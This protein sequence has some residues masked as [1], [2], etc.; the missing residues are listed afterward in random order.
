MIIDFL[1]VNKIA[2][3]EKAKP[4]LPVIKR[5][6]SDTE[7]T[8]NLTADTIRAAIARWPSVVSRCGY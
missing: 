7:N 6:I 1:M 8:E 4:D 3:S 2:I 5:M